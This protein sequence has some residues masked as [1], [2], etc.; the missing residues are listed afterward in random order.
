MEMPNAAIN[1]FVWCILFNRVEIAK[2][3]IQN[4]EVNILLI[5]QYIIKINIPKSCVFFQ[6]Q[7]L[8]SLFA[9]FIMRKFDNFY[10]N[11]GIFLPVAEYVKRLTV[12]AY[13]IINNLN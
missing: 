9:S 7:I 10:K 2:I 3:I 12:Y 4:G 11:E 13:F 5:I 1:L 6:S 8:F